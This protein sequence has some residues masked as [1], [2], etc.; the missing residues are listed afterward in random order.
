MEEGERR[1]TRHLNVRAF[2]I[3]VYIQKVEIYRKKIND[4]TE[5]SEHC[6]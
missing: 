1:E 2:L 5:N 3:F 4:E 6:T